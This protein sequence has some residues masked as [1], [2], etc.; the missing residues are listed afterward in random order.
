MWIKYKHS[1]A[2]GYGDSGFVEVPELEELK[3]EYEGESNKDDLEDLVASYLEDWGIDIGC[4]Y[5]SDK[6]RGFNAEIVEHPDSEWLLR[7]I[8]TYRSNAESYT[9]KA[10]RYQKILDEVGFITKDELSS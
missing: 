4:S 6:Y 2:W 9:E 8:K 7:R 1:F 10:D 3:K 5:W